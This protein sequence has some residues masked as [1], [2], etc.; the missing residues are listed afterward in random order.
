MRRER[1][2][3]V[4]VFAVLS[5]SSCGCRDPRAA[6]RTYERTFNDVVLASARALT[7]R[8]TPPA[9]AHP[10]PG[11]VTRMEAPA[12]PGGHAIL[13]VNRVSA[14]KTKVTVGV[15]ESRA[16]AS[17]LSEVFLPPHDTFAE[18]T[19]LDRINRELDAIATEIEPQTV[20][21]ATAP[22]SESAEPDEPV[23]TPAEPLGEPQSGKPRPR[24]YVE[25]D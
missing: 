9:V 16:N 15:G 14:G 10:K 19:L 21:P 8:N 18:R 1:F 12:S 24:E 13:T 25:P 6:S 3:L 5:A 23:V 17:E 22:P 4:L 20:V 11:Y 7:A 2:G